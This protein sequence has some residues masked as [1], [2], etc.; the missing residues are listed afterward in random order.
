MKDKATF[1]TVVGGEEVELTTIAPTTKISNE[2]D[3]VRAA[4]WAKASK[5]LKDATG[6]VI[7]DAAPL[8]AEIEKS[9]LPE[10]DG[11]WNK[12][13]D[14]KY[15]EV[16]MRLLRNEKRLKAGAG[17]FKSVAEA[18]A[19]AWSMRE[20]R[21]TRYQLRL[22]RD[23]LNDNSAES[24]ADMARLNY[25]VYACTLKDGKQFFSSLDDYYARAN[26][27]YTGDAV[28]SLIKLMNDVED[29][30]KSPENDFL[31]A[32]GF[33]DE[34]YRRVNSDGKFIDEEGKL[35]NEFGQ[36][37]DEAGNILDMDGDKL[38]PDGEF[39]VEFIPF[40]D[41]N[42]NVIEPKVRG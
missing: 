8:R 14:E 23:S 13:Q 18:A 36:L 21:E 6:K 15:R 41:E 7:R 10:H 22:L 17:A 16:T 37:V 12:E 1:K 32:Y 28:T 5:P 42:G 35:V 19:T 24:F 2:S 26:E 9:I 11:I 20:D 38:T 39:D 33:V 3:L 29:V 27:S 4:A 40:T 25:L 31:Y 30:D 34:K